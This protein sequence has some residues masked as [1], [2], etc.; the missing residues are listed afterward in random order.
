MQQRK[1]IGEILIEAGRI[2]QEQ[3]EKAL[4]MQ[5]RSGVRLGKI[6]VEMGAITET[7]LLRVL[8]RSMGIPLIDLSAIQPDKEAVRLV[9]MSLAERHVVIPIRKKGNRLT[10]AMLDPTNF[11]AIDDLRMVTQSEIEPVLAVEADIQRA[12]DQYY[13]VSDLVEKSISQLQKEDYSFSAELETSEDAPVI[14][15]VNSLIS[16]AIKA[17]ASDIHL[18]PQETGMRV[19]FRVDGILRETASF[20]KHTQGAIISRVKIISNLDIAEKRVPQDGRIQIQESG[21][22]IDIRVSSLPTIYGEKIVM[23]ILDQKS[24]ILAIDSLG[25]SEK[26]LRKF[27]KMYKHTYGMILVTGPTGSGKTTTLYSVLNELNSPTQ[28]IITV[29]DPVEY[30]LSGINQVQVSNKAGMTFATGLRSIL[31]QDPNIIMV[32]EIRDRETAEIAIRAALTGHLVLST[33]HTNEAAGAVTRLVDMGIEPFLVASAVI[34]CVAQ[35]LLRKI[36][37]ECRQPYVPFPDSPE[38]LAL[39]ENFEFTAAL[40]HG[41]GCMHCGNTGYRGRLAAH[42]V[43]PMSPALRELV[44]KRAATGALTDLAIAEGMHTIQQDAMSK[45]QEGKTTLKEMLRLTYDDNK[46]Y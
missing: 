33:L 44:V 6:L 12:I 5:K 1:R 37:P 36:C 2:T 18:E 26:N 27:R 35:R 32:G 31:R 21:R 16:Q 4:A 22:A 20:P 15:I 40:Y 11:F 46:E 19:R 39:P 43:M 42:E 25:F 9:P 14:N 29:E 17:G 24:S 41:T 7:G 34:G 38:F 30:R 10:V 8:E 13:G 45:V 28:N 3:L 23:R